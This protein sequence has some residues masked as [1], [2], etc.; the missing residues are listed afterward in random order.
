MKSNEILCFQSARIGVITAA[1]S[2]PAYWGQYYV[3]MFYRYQVAQAVWIPVMEEDTD[4]AFLQENV[5]L[6][7]NM[8]GIFFGGGEP[9]RLAASLMIEVDGVRSDTP[10]MEA[11]RD[12]L[13]SGGML[14][15]TSAG[16]MALTDTV[17]V[18]GG[19]SYEALVYGA[20]EDLTPGSSNL[21]FDPLGGVRV[22]SD[23]LMDAHFSQSAR[24]GR[25]VRLVA[26]TGVN[27]AIGV[28]E[29]TALACDQDMVVCT[30]LGSAGVWYMDMS[31]AEVSNTTDTGHWSCENVTTGY[32]TKD[33]ILNMA[34]WM[35]TFADYKENVINVSFIRQHDNRSD[36]RK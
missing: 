31:T 23:V 17:I 8:T 30:V 29:D 14:A 1:N 18:T 19:N 22:I 3:D 28:D 11:V 7:R 27:R 34:N 15:G 21:T 9:A 2:D 26:D 24:Q 6:V 12:L 35:V 4:S 36:Q 25:L 5:D 20:H 32:I 33:D 13:E 10:V 16:I